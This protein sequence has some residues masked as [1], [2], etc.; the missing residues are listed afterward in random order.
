MI[1]YRTASLW[2]WLC[3][4]SNSR[5]AFWVC[6]IQQRWESLYFFTRL[7]PSLA[8]VVDKHLLRCRW[9]PPCFIVWRLFYLDINSLQSSPHFTVTPDLIASSSHALWELLW[10]DLTA[11]C[12]CVCVC[13]C[14][15]LG[16]AEVSSPFQNRQLPIFCHPPLGFLPGTGPDQTTQGE[17]RALCVC[18]CVSGVQR[19]DNTPTIHSQNA[20]AAEQWW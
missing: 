14:C 3:S 12:L 17:K 6:D 19:S 2:R 11:M 18:L 4:I 10:L 7:P 20:P 9:Q 16:G 1:T 8:S 5:L 15:S 13:V